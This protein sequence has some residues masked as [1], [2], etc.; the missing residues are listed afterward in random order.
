MIRRRRRRDPAADPSGAHD[1][2]LVHAHPCEDSFHRAVVVA[3]VRG[4]EAG[5]HQV[6]VLDLYGL[7]FRAA[8]TVEEHRAYHAEQPILDPMVA[9]HARLVQEATTMVF[10]YPTWWG[11]LPAIMKGWFERVMVP[12]VGFRLDERT[13]KVRPALQQVRHLVGVSTYGSPW[14]LVK[15]ATDGGRRIVTRALRMSCGWT[16]RPRWVG[17]YSIDT[18]GSVERAAFLDRVEHTMASL[19]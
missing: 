15:L 11:S 17:L 1:V 5:G 10:I 19:S 8:M 2:L 14:T 18:A 12:G 16:A 6:T 9:E 4:L 13:G 7:D 3:A